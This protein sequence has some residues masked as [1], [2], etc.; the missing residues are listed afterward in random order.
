[1]FDQLVTVYIGDQDPVFLVQFPGIPDP[2]SGDEKILAQNK[3]IYYLCV[4]LLTIKNLI[5]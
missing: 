4:L 5:L 2:R 3:K 1:V